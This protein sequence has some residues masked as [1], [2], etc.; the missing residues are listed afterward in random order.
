MNKIEANLPKEKIDFI[1]DAY[2]KES[3]YW[4]KTALEKGNE[5]E[6]KQVTDLAASRAFLARKDVVKN[7]RNFNEIIFY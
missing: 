4:E 7:E 1:N 2:K 3:Q 5:D 6:T